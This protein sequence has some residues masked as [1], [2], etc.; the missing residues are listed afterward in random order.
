MFLEAYF[1]EPA[2]ALFRGERGFP[3]EFRCLFEVFLFRGGAPETSGKT[4]GTLRCLKVCF[5]TH[6]WFPW[7][8]LWVPLEVFGEPWMLHWA[9]FSTPE[10]PQREKSG[11]RV[12][13]KGFIRVQ[14]QKM[15]ITNS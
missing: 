15:T 7:A 3:S 5:W 8:P 6:C 1:K 9:Y 14:A 2:T 12:L 11:H 13:K 4:L 10:G